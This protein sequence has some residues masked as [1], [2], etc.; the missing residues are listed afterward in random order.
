MEIVVTNSSQIAPGPLPSTPRPTETGLFGSHRHNMLD[1]EASFYSGYAWSLNPFLSVQEGINHLRE[2]LRRLA[3]TS[4]GWQRDE[5]ITNVFLLGG[6]VAAAVDDYIAGTRYEFSKLADALPIVRPLLPIAAKLQDFGNRI[7]AFRFQRLHQW[8]QE[9]HAAL[10]EYSMSL[11]GLDASDQVAGRSAAMLSSLLPPPFPVELLKQRP[12]IPGAFR[13]KDY[14]HYDAIRLGEKFESKFPDRQ[15]LLFVIGLRTAGSFFSSVLCA[16]LKSKGYENVRWVTLR[17]KKGI[18]R[19]ES[20]SLA[21]GKQDGAL[22]LVIDEHPN[23]GVTLAKTADVLRAEGFDSENVVYLFPEH[24]GAPNWREV[25]K[26][27]GLSSIRALH[28]EPEESYKYKLLHSGMAEKQIIEYF[29]S[30][31][32]PVQSIAPAPRENVALAGKSDEKVSVRFK[33]VYEVRLK[34]PTGNVETRFILA[35]SVGW[36]WFGYGAFFAGTYLAPFVPTVLGLRDGILYEEWLPDVDALGVKNSRSA[37]VNMAACYIAAR[38]RHLPLEADPSR[39]LSGRDNHLGNSIL[40]GLLSRVYGRGAILKYPRFLER[41]SAAVNPFPTLIDGK[42]NRPEWIPTA[43]SY[44]KTDFEHH[45]LGKTGLNATDPACDLAAA[46][47]HLGLSRAEE[48][49]LLDQYR[50]QSGDAGVMDRLF[51]NKLIVGS[52]EF[53]KTLEKLADP[54]M[55]NRHEEFNRRYIAAWNFLVC[56]TARYCG[57]HCRRAATISWRG[58]VVFLDLDGVVDRSLFPFPST[59]PAAMRAISLLHSHDFTLVTNTARSLPQVKEYCEAYGFAGGIAEYGSVLW[60]AVDSREKI[61]VSR[62]SLAELE[63]VREELRRIPGV[64]V[65]D[66]YRY[67]V[68]TYMYGEKGTEP[69]PKTLIEG[70]L[71]RNHFGRMTFHQTNIDTAIVA[72]GITKGTGLRAFVDWVGNPAVFT[73]AV[74]DSETDLSM[75]REVEQSYAPS[76]IW[77]KREA[78]RLGCRIAREPY[79]SGLLSIART[80]SHPEGGDCER[81]RMAQVSW[82]KG[83]DLFLDSLE[84]A[85]QEPLRRW[86]SILFDPTMLRAFRE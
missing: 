8:R 78:M 35:K 56:H 40:A 33:R 67:M 63:A 69:V 13:S 39:E 7:R 24:S 42:L 22:A 44:V 6:M 3:S 54:D 14:S 34:G 77:C 27:R 81:C 75:F 20:Q 86:L 60:E 48:E 18:A 72:K 9:W 30:Q 28:L 74:G 71:S 50:I 58:P 82:K 10:V 49:H 1:E 83:T 31:N 19:W 17:A 38:V 4:S 11:P 59:T 32:A 41:L 15:R 2:E 46:I 26:S 70:L 51:L 29:Q 57:Q 36:G 64:F 62:E 23:G 85:D 45:G 25:L 53:L 43:S 52:W 47:L 37:L 16:F 76:H 55:T 84:V 12:R 73:A 68:R 80:L 79:Q 61:L 21:R 66:T 5:V 65:D